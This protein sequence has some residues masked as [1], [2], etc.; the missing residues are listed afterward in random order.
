[1]DPEGLLHNLR[2]NIGWCGRSATG[3]EEM[4]SEADHIK[5]FEVIDFDLRE[6]I[7]RVWITDMER[8]HVGIPFFL[9]FPTFTS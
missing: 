4:F 3:E 5:W 1:M 6:Q 7:K 9:W 2:N 8:L